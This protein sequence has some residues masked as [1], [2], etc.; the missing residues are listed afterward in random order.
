MQ[1][2]QTAVP[3]TVT[4]ENR[5]RAVITG[6]E[7]VECFNG[8]TAVITT[9]MG[10]VSVSGAGLRVEQLEIAQG[11]VTL[12]G[13]VDALEYGEVRKAGLFRRIMR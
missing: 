12:E 6:V 8:E 5:A 9:G 4:L 3:Q 2:G 10:A 7:D 13:R 1:N 11:R